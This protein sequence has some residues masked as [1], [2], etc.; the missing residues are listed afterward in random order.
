M[1]HNRGDILGLFAAVQPLHGIA[2]HAVEV[3]FIKLAKTARITLR[4]LHQQPFVLLPKIFFQLF[5]FPQFWPQSRQRVLRSI[6]PSLRITVQKGKRLRCDLC[7]A[8]ALAC[9]L[10]N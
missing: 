10:K 4:R 5:F 7:G 2:V 6:P 9:K 8:G 1:K 3:E